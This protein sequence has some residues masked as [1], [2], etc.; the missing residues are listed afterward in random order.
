[1]KKENEKAEV[2]LKR[3]LCIFEKINHPDRYRVLESLA[4]IYEQKTIEAGKNEQLKQTA[5][6]KGQAIQYLSQALAITQTEFSHE[7][8]H[9]KRIKIRLGQLENGISAYHLQNE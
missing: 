7:S 1:M 6:L 8:A 5:I 3:S 4:F 2:F 9:V